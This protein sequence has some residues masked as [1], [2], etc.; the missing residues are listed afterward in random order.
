MWSLFYP[1]PVGAY[2]GGFI[3]GAK[4][5]SA[6]VEIYLDTDNDPRTGLPATSGVSGDLGTGGAEYVISLMEIG[7]TVGNEKGKNVNRQVLDPSIS[8]GEERLGSDEMGGWFP[9]VER[10]VNAVRLAVPLSVL[11][12]KNGAGIRVTVRP[13]FCAPKS[14]IVTLS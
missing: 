14:K 12:L 10:D 8:K 9:K 4:K 3:N 2:L 13:G 1:K 7:T 6:D 11:G 5:V